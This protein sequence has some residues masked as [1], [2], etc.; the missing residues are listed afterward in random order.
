MATI[1]AN[2]AVIPIVL[3][4]IFIICSLINW[5]FYVYKVEYTDFWEACQIK[6]VRHA[7]A[8]PP[9]ASCGWSQTLPPL[10]S[11]PFRITNHAESLI[12]LPAEAKMPM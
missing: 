9:T 2:K 7:F 8:L 4:V 5:S 6:G 12:S 3:A 1:T 11:C 10:P